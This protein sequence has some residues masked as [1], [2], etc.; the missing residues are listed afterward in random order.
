MGRGGVDKLFE[1]CREAEIEDN[2]NQLLIMRNILAVF[3]ASM[4]ALAGSFDENSNIKATDLP[5]EIR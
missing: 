5:Y 2:R 1:A 3:P 4:V